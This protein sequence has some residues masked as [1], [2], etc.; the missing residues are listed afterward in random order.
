MRPLTCTEMHDLAPEMALGVLSGEDRGA[1]IAHLESCSRCHVDLSALADAADQL[2][3]VAPRVDPPPGFEVR[4]LARLA[5]ETTPRLGSGRPRR[6]RCAKPAAGR[7]EPGAC[8]LWE[9]PPRRS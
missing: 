2:L 3:L 7:D 4:V 8:G 1:A 5:A 9:S 6:R